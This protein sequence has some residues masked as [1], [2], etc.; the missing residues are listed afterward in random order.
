MVNADGDWVVAEPD[1]ASWDQY[2]AK[3]KVSA[4]AQEAAAAGDKE[5][6]S[7]GLECP[8]DKR[9]FVEPT[10]TPCCSTTFC[11]DCINNALLENDLRCP[12]CATENIL[13]DDL[14]VDTDMV[15]KIESFEKEGKAAAAQRRKSK[16]PSNEDEPE[17]ETTSTASQDERPRSRGLAKPSTPSSDTQATRQTKKRPADIELS[18]DRKKRSPSFTTAQKTAITNTEN[19]ASTTQIPKAPQSNAGNNQ[20]NI[21]NSNSSFS[22]IN[23]MMFPTTNPFM[24]MP[25]P[26]PMPMTMAPNMGGM[27]QMF[28]H[29]FMSNGA[30]N[31]MNPMFN[32]NFPQQPMSMGGQPFPHGMMPNMGFGQQNSPSA[33]NLMGTSNNGFAQGLGR[34]M[35]QF[36]NQQRNTNE[37][38]SAYFRNPVNPHRHQGRR[39]M[40]RPADFRDI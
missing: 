11:H 40:S 25:M 15:A 37:E 20:H 19:P 22:G 10:L 12:H 23:P 24:P 4:A 17:R 5:L 14:K 7:R 29:M 27:P 8:V 1:K 30:F 35:P 26:M 39:N 2:Q 13:I 9:L 3:A 21:P 36:K 34:G 28:D 32:P 18:N 16:S 33:Q 31:N 38:D 6:Q